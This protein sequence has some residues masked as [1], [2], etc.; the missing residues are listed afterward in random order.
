MNFTIQ[1]HNIVKPVLSGPHIKRAAAQVPFSPPRFA[2][3]N[4]Y[5]QRA[6]LSSG[7]MRVIYGF[8]RVH[9]SNRR[10][11]TNTYGNIQ[12]TY[13][14]EYTGYIPI[15]RSNIRWQEGNKHEMYHFSFYTSFSHVLAHTRA[16]EVPHTRAWYIHARVRPTHEQTW[17]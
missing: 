5:T 10:I 6:P 9:T 13:D 15:H 8:I 2:L 7:H 4:A 16:P 11:H 3:K 1:S 17:P 12:V 14:Y